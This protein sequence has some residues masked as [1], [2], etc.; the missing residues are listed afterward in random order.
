MGQSLHNF[1]QY[2]CQQVIATPCAVAEHCVEKPSNNPQGREYYPNLFHRLPA[3]V[4]KDIVERLK[5]VFIFNNT[6]TATWSVNVAAPANTANSLPPNRPLGA[7][8][9]VGGGV[10]L[11]HDLMEPVMI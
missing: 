8:I 4:Y 9:K 1:Q 10:G 2:V 5:T 11:G 3:D 7:L 6:P